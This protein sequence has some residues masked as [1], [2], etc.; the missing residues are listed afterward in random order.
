MEESEVEKNGKDSGAEKNGAV[1]KEILTGTNE[2]GVDESVRATNQD[3]LTQEEEEYDS[4]F[5][6]DFEDEFGPEMDEEEDYDQQSASSGISSIFNMINKAQR[7]LKRDTA[8]AIA[9]MASN[10]GSSG[11]R[12]SCPGGRKKR[13]APT[14]SELAQ[15]LLLTGGEEG[16]SGNIVEQDSHDEK[17]N[18]PKKKRTCTTN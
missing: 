14:E 13:A 2:Q 9:S 12:G 10:G 8:S 17:D 16:T 6:D 5:E 15:P 7:S 4:A 18:E 3:Q 11:S 1:P